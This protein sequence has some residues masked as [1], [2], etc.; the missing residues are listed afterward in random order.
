MKKRPGL[1][2]RLVDAIV[3]SGQR[4]FEAAQIDR[5]SVEQ[6]ARTNGERP[7]NEDLSEGLPTMRARCRDVVQNN[8]LVNGVVNTHKCDVAGPDGPSLDVQSDDETYN[9]E[10][11]DVWRDVITNCD[12]NRQL[13]FVDFI[14][15]DVEMGWTAGDSI[16]QMLY[17]RRASTPIKLRMLAISPDR[18]D[19]PY[20]MFGDPDVVM[21][22]KLDEA[23]G[24]VSYY[25][26]EPSHVGPYRYMTGKFTKVDAS[27]IVHVFESVEP[28]Q[29]RG[30]PWLAS[31]LR[32][33][34]H[35]DSFDRET[36]EAARSAALLGVTLETQQGVTGPE[37]WVQTTGKIQIPTR[38]MTYVAPGYTAKQI[39]SSHPGNNYID[40]Q[41]EQFRKIGRPVGMPLL[42]ILMDARTHNYSSA[43]YDGQVYRRHLNVIQAR[44]TRQRCN[45]FAN[46]VLLDAERTGLIRRRPNRVRLVWG[47]SQ[48]PEID[49]YKAAQ[50][51]EIELR[52]GLK[53]L[54]QVCAS[55]NLNFEEVV[56]ARLRDD[57][58]LQSLG[59]PTVAE[60]LG[61]MTTTEPATTQDQNNSNRFNVEL[62]I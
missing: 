31:S 6:Y 9:R 55:Y 17:D 29:V 18:L 13:A 11:E 8:A 32:S 2:R 44:I 1:F 45:P 51:A 50:A 23:G 27:Q 39:Q 35:S 58:Y 4:R 38:S 28:G 12:Y 61:H 25:I 22:I 53:S 3:P 54:S 24:P 60:M 5:D 57:E 40:F 16:T 62:A 21:G 30:I 26:S 48:P 49:P 7:Y 20:Q 43:R 10:A 47:W 59:M 33:I 52:L 37:D 46:Q 15:Q 42:T 19:T 41:H 56:Q 14:R 36:I 34:S